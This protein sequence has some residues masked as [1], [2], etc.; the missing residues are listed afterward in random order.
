MLLCDHSVSVSAFLSQYIYIYIYIREKIRGKVDELKHWNG[1]KN[2]ILSLFQKDFIR[3]LNKDEIS[4]FV[5][6]YQLLHLFFF[7]IW[8]DLQNLSSLSLSLS[9][10]IYIYRYIYISCGP[11]HMDEQRQDDQLEPIYNSSVPI[12]DIALKTSQERWTI[13]TGRE[14]GSGRPC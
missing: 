1:F 2:D 5:S 6:V 3:I 13:E 7:F 4:F 10:Y 12:Q 9:I 14:R 11:L 8:S